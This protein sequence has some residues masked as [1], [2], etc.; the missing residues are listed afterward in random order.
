[1][2]KLNYNN[3]NEE[4]YTFKC[5]NGLSVF[6]A[7]NL[8]SKNFFISLGVRYGASVIRYKKNDEIYDVTPG[9]AH[10]IEH[11]VLDFT[12]DKEAELKVRNLGSYPNACTNYATTRYLMFGSLDINENM[13][14]LFDRVF[15]PNFKASDI[16][17]EKGIILEEYYMYK[18]DPSSAIYDEV[19]ESIYT[20]YYMKKPVLGM[21]SDIKSITK[22]EIERIY[23]D[24]YVTENMY[25]V[26]TGNFNASDAKDFIIDY[27]KKIKSKPFNAKVLSKKEPLK[28]KTS[29]KEV[30]ME[31]QE[32]KV[33]LAFKFDSRDINKMNDTKKGYYLS[34]LLNSLLSPTGTLFEKYKNDKL[35]STSFGTGKA[36][37]KNFIDLKIITD[38]SKPNEYI[39]QIKKDINEFNITKEDFER[40]KRMLL[41]EVILNFENI[42]SANDFISYQV[43]KFKKPILNFY[44]LLNGLT[45]EECLKVR[46]LINLDNLFVIKVI[47]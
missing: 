38:T 6:L 34:I 14:V 47:K 17:K 4:V 31:V 13:R 11:R 35:I 45:Y 28:M 37:D 26:I 8:L 46:K 25:L 29:Y 42:Q 30:Q 39:E 21:P 20:N 19:C 40:K 33:A 16:E 32:P 23:N 10:F 24:F 9:I 36:I 41:S 15:S 12:K 44:D 18:D 43:N 1:M 2:K 5:D 7:P 22:K 27:M 3:I